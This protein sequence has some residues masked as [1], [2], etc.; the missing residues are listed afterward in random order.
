MAIVRE[1]K[2][3]IPSGDDLREPTT[4]GAFTVGN[5]INDGT[6][7]WF[8]GHFVN[9]GSGLRR[10]NDLEVKWGELRAGETKRSRHTNDQGTTLT[11][12]I[13]GRFVV[14]FPALQID[15]V[16]ERPGDYVIFAPRLEHKWQSETQSTVVTVRWPSLPSNPPVRVAQT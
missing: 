7:G 10:T 5:A 3:R 13:R 2:T 15:V 14:T 4:H 11:L 1:N 9:D 8:I 16:L 6:H 12:L